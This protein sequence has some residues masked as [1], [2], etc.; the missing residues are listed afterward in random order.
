MSAQ[1]PEMDDDPR[2]DKAA[3]KEKDDVVAILLQQHARIREL[4]GEISGAEGDRKK[5]V[6][7]ELRGLLAVHETAEEMIVRPAAKD[8]AGDEEAGA[9]NAEEKE[10]NKALARLEKLDVNSPEFDVQ[11]AQFQQDVLSHA[12]HEETEEFPALESGCTPEQRRTMGRRLLTAEKLAPTHPHP[13]AAG[14]PA[15]QWT[16]GPFASLLDR[17]RDAF[18]TSAKR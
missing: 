15:M 3:G 9:R 10:A 6:F 17:A 8:V 14:S 2:R 7:N 4:F 12:Q 13:T 16:L 1:Y 5:E 11:L 18:S